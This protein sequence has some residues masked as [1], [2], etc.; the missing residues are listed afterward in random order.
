MQHYGL[1]TR[2]LD[3][4]TNPLV[5][6]FFSTEDFTEDGFVYLI[7]PIELNIKSDV[8]VLLLPDHAFVKAISQLVFCNSKIGI[9]ESEELH[10][11]SK[12]MQQVIERFLTESIENPIAIQPNITNHRLAKQSGCFTIHGNSLDTDKKAEKKITDIVPATSIQIPKEIKPVLRLQ[13]AYL[14]IDEANLFPEIEYTSKAIK[15]AY[16]I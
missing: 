14:A 4:T 13:L 12:T 6:L 10:F 16:N 5:A 2:L 7:N 15:N 11:A 1:P 9:L 8:C 3:W